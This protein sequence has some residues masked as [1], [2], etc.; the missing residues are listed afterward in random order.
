MEPKAPSQTAY[1]VARMRAGHQVL[2]GGKIFTDPYA[3]PLV[4]ETPEGLAA[5]LA[6][7]SD[8]T[9]SRTYM[10][11]RSRIGEDWL[12]AAYRRGVRQAVI[13]GAGFDT[14]GLRNPYQ[15]LAVFEVDHPA[16]QSWKQ[17]RLTEAGLNMPPSLT[18]VPANLAAD[19]LLRALGGSTF[20]AAEPAFFLWL[21]VVPYLARADVFKTL[22]AIA[23]IPGA[24]VVF[25]YSEPLDNYP[26]SVQPFI[27]EMARKVAT[28]GEP[29]LSY[30]DPT[31]LGSELQRL[32][33]AEVEDLD[34]ESV[35][36]WISQTKS[37]AKAPGPHL[38][39]ARRC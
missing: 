22:A 39:R 6:A 8:D 9:I 12:H 10:A 3:C 2:D 27:E 37:E 32:G 11:T 31:Q 1:A 23:E 29:W 36:N 33:Y 28:L 30:F 35:V 20:R 25:D 14:F 26:A 16:T 5:Q 38:I 18:F 17:Q 34:R 21:G 24:E 7:E 4:G 13:L 15:D 19:E